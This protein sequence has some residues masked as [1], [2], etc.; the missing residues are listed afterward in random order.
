MATMS[1]LDSRTCWNAL[2][3]LKGDFLK[4]IW[5]ILRAILFALSSYLL[6]SLERYRAA[7]VCGFIVGLEFR[8]VVRRSPVVIDAIDEL[9]FA[10]IVF[11]GASVGFVGV[12]AVAA[13]G[14]SSA[15][16][17]RVVQMV[18]MASAAAVSAEH[19]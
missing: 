8:L 19:I 12:G 16:F 18:F 10:W 2:A 14:L 4:L 6:S 13:P 17:S 9:E 3:V 15:S 7:S 11:V 1:N 5:A